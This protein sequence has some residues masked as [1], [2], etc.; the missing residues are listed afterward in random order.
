MKRAADAGDT[1]APQSRKPATRLFADA[2]E[3]LAAKYER[4][5]LAAIVLALVILGP[6]DARA[7]Q[8]GDPDFCY[9]GWVFVPSLSSGFHM[10]D[11]NVWHRMLVP[12]GHWTCPSG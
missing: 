9:G 5:A 2:V 1:L 8:S 4:A 6:G 11:E 3:G 10:D 12:G 7:D